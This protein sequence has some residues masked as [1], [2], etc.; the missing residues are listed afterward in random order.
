MYQNCDEIFLIE[1]AQ[2]HNKDAMQQLLCRFQPLIKKLSYP[3]HYED[4]KSELELFF[5]ELIMGLDINRF[6]DK[7][8]RQFVLSY[9]YKSLKHKYISL[10]KKNSESSFCETELYENVAVSDEN[11]EFS[12]ICFLDL[13]SCLSE[14]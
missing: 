7:D 11:I 4:A 13:L 10:I 2:S 1:L 8:K 9:I 14:S 12:K 3:L 5:L 6:P